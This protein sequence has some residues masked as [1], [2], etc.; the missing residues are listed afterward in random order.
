MMPVSTGIGAPPD[1]R[2]RDVQN[3]VLDFCG[4]FGE[5]LAERTAG[6]LETDFLRSYYAT[7]F[8]RDGRPLGLAVRGY[9][10]RLKLV[11]NEL[12]RRPDGAR[13]IDA[14][15]GYG[16]ESLLFAG[17]GADVTGVELRADLT[18]RARSR[19]D[20]HRAAAG[21]RFRLQFENAH[22]LRYLRN[23]EPADIIWAMESVSHIYP[24][25]EFLALA[26]DRLRHGGAL[27]VADPNTLNPYAWLSGIKIR[28]AIR[29]TPKRVF[30][31]PW[32][33]EPVD[34]GQEN[35]FSV[36]AMKNKMAAA[37]FEIRAVH[38]SG[39]LGSTLWP[40]ALAARPSF[41]GLMTGFQSAIRKI[42]P[43]TRLGANYTILAVKVS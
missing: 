16:T 37:G 40:E 30:T 23:A 32:S 15:C 20:F 9:T 43:L 24:P 41:V 28:G 2:K 14:G 33:G 3:I 11:L 4:R 12:R 6:G 26:F 27:I 1:W 7:L 13:L 18:D 38:M 25:E 31:D 17:L 35:R 21:S 42:P 19:I 39:F 10:E 22:V 36:G 34:Y 29:H 8:G 5:E